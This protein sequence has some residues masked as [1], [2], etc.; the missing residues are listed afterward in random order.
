MNIIFDR[1]TPINKDL[2]NYQITA[3]EDI[4]KA[5]K[6]FRT[7]MFQMPTGTGKTRLFSSIIKDMHEYGAK[8]REPVKILILAHREELISQISESI[9][10]KY[11]IAHGKIKSRHDEEHHYPTQIASVQTLYR[12]IE[13][14]IR[15][16]FDIII[17]DEAHHVLAKKTYRDICNKFP[18]AKL[19]GVTATPY[20]LNA[21]P[22]PPM[23][24]ILVQSK[25]IYQFIKDGYLS[26]I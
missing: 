9:G 26:E 5:W 6:I 11:G 17:I 16:D 20:R 22:F 25:S 7:V 24:D 3:K 23:F 18:N 12:R 21:E 15:K 8:R 2:R 14:W 4:Y 1:I 13:R 19:L 10:K